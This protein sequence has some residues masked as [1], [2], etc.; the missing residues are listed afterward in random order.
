MFHTQSELRD[1]LKDYQNINDKITR[2]V[3]SGELIRLK[4]GMFE[5]SRTT[6]PEIVASVLCTPSYLSFEWAL[7]YYGLIPEYVRTF[8]SA[9]VGLN[10]IKTYKNDFGLFTYRDIPAPAYPFGQE[11]RACGYAGFRIATPEKA[12]LD[13]LNIKPVVRTIKDME[14]LLFED[15]RIDEEIFFGLD[16]SEDDELQERYKSTNVRTFFKYLHSR[17]YSMRKKECG[18]CRI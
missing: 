14:D 5:D 1:T 13:T 2:M 3:R 15:M 16:F 18:S 9:S 17:S 12:L 10:K 4:K 11:W 6:P 8:T 7:S